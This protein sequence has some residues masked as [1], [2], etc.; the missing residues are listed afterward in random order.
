[1]PTGVDGQHIDGLGDR[2]SVARVEL[3]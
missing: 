2:R 3:V 1:V